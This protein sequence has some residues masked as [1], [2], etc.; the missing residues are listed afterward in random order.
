MITYVT[1][2]QA[3]LQISRDAVC[4]VETA[5]MH[6]TRLQVCAWGRVSP[7]TSMG[8]RPNS[9]GLTHRIYS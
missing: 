1:Y 2:Q 9:L 4:Y 5:T 8:K 3:I 7:S 6:Q